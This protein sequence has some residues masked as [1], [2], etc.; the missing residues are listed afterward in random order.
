MWVWQFTSLPNS[1]QVQ[2][3]LSSIRIWLKMLRQLYVQLSGLARTSRQWDMWQL[4]QNSEEFL[5]LGVSVANQ[6]L[7]TSAICYLPRP[8]DDQ[9]GI[10]RECKATVDE[11]PRWRYMRPGIFGFPSS[12]LYFFSKNFRSW[13]FWRIRAVNRQSWNRLVPRSRVRAIIFPYNAPFTEAT[14]GLGQNEKG[15]F[16]IVTVCLLRNFSGD[17]FA[18]KCALVQT[19]RFPWSSRILLRKSFP[20]RQFR[21][22]PC[23]E[24]YHIAFRISQLFLLLFCIYIY[25]RICFFFQFIYL[26]FIL[27]YFFAEQSRRRFASVS[28]SKCL[29]KNFLFQFRWNNPFEHAMCLT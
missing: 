29:E 2:T 26:Y 1:C 18:F 25:I 28:C 8:N 14:S 22:S 23:S 7:A 16:S 27:F 6:T 5:S 3:F 12:Y 15:S 19:T 9:S 10:L 21:N 24:I 13:K 4:F 17:F 20:C 11:Q